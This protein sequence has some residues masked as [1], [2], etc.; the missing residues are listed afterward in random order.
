MTEPQI[1]TK[2]R[3][4]ISNDLV[5]KHKKSSVGII[6][7]GSVAYAPYIHVTPNSDI[8]LLIITNNIKVFINEFIDDHQEV[9]KLNN[10]SFEGY[11]FK[12]MVDDVPVSFHILTCDAFDVITKCFVADI[13]VFR[14]KSKEENYKLYGFERNTYEYWVKNIT[15]EEFATG[16]RTIVPVGFINLDRYFLGIHRD[17]LISNP[18]II[19]DTDNF[20][21]N[22]IDRLWLNLFQICVMSHLDFYKR[23]IWI[24]STLSIC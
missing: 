1:E 10:R 6:L 16:V 9:S 4:D 18:I 17:K 8:D 21:V 24:N 12:K 13:R 14:I 19:H 2:K 11:C 7:T 22:G 15:L 3:I 20:I 5:Q 23:L